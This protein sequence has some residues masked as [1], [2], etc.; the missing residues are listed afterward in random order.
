MKRI[1]VALAV[2]AILLAAVRAQ[3]LDLIR[4]G[5]PAS[6][7]VLPDNAT[8]LEQEGAQTLVKYLKLASGAELPIAKESDKPAGT[9]ISIGH[10][11]LAERAGV[12]EK[13][14]KFDGYRLVAKKGTLYLLGRDQE[15]MKAPPGQ[16]D[17]IGAQ[18]SRCAALGL[19]EQLGFRWL[20]P[21]PMGTYV[22]EMKT[23]AVP[24]DL[25]YMHEPAFMYVAGRLYTWGDWSL[26]NSFRKAARLF[27]TGGHTWNEAVPVSMWQEHPEYFRMQG[28][29]RIRPTELDHQLCP[30]NPEV[31]RLITEYT[32]K[33]F[34]EGH[35][36]VALGHPD[37]W[38]SCEC[39]NCLALGKGEAAGD[40]VHRTNLKI[41]EA[42]RKKYPNGYVHM[43]V[44]GPTQT[45]PVA[46]KK[47]PAN[48]MAE[49]APPTSENL[50]LWNRIIPGGNTVYVYYMGPYHQ[51]GLCPIYTPKQATEDVKMLLSRGVKGIY[52]CGAGENWGAQGPVCY[53]IGRVATNPDT[54]WSAALDEYCNLTF[55]NAGRT[56]RQYYDLLYARLE[57]NI[58]GESICDTLTGTYTPE[59]L[60]RLANLLA[61]AKTQAAGDERA[62][63]WIRLTEL[64]CTQ[65]TLLAKVF[66]IYQVYQLQP[67]VSN[68]EQ[69][70]DAVAAWHAFCKQIADLPNKE[71]AFCVN[72]FPNVGAWDGGLMSTNY[73]TLASPFTWDFDS[74]LKTG[75]LPGAKRTQ[76]VF[77][78]LKNAPVIDGDI[79]KEAWKDAPWI[80]VKGVALQKMEAV[81]RAKLGYDEKNLYFAFECGEPLFDQM[82]ITQCGRDGK[83][84]N[85]EDIEILLAPDGVGQKRIQLCVSPAPG[86]I[87]DGRYG[88]IDDPLNPLNV[89]KMADVSWNANVSTAYKLDAAN[90]R[91]T[92]EIAFPFSELDAACPSEG[93]RWRGNLGRER[94]RS[95]WDSAK[96][97]FD[98]DEIY[99]WAPN[100]QGAGIPDPAAF[101]DL[102]FGRI[103]QT[104]AP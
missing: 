101:G 96:W 45:P 99:L 33:R 14:L 84:Y 61:L 83:V 92:M 41:I 68:L 20:A 73:N 22:P 32:L 66:H 76:T 21:T 78:R 3:A 85:T 52:Y 51:T 104:E 46:F 67:S 50:E 74:L 9:L 13:G 87:W 93:A 91:W 18:G 79:Y 19:L 62:L 12:T 64:S 16:G 88:Y 40:Q 28:G 6:T 5:R 4:D 48:T 89:Y 31:V 97:R 70:R 47:Y 38:K 56:M 24:D 42:C 10:T 63:G 7:I 71:P 54:E 1:A 2:G 8:P 75:Y 95:V 58:E 36:I 59:V 81:T 86:S 55:R 39:P 72:Y 60:E 35:D 29:V 77:T 34:E 26:A 37:G 23:V 65:F 30:S 53:A 90:K 98:E 11:K 44:Y 80:N 15:I 25:Q 49:V 82:K 27:S 94:H 43:I 102:F 100:L 103:P 69:M 57:M 17:R